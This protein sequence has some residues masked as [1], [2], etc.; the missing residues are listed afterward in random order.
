MGGNTN[1]TGIPTT[2][3]PVEMLVTL[4]TGSTANNI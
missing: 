1:N 3:L 4:T 2:T